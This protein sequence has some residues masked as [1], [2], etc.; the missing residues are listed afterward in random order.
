MIKHKILVSAAIIVAVFLALWS[1][2][3]DDDS[4][5]KSDGFNREE[6]LV[7]WADNIIIPAYKAFQTHVKSLK[8]ASATFTTTPNEANLKAL[9]KA[10]KD[11]YLKFQD[12]SMFEIGPAADV[13]FRLFLNTYPAAAPEESFIVKA[14]YNLEHTGSEALQGFP[15]LDYLLY[16]LGG[17]K[18]SDS[19]I[20]S[21]YTGSNASSYIEYLN[22]IV[23]RMESLTDKVAGQWENSYRDA[24]VD[25]S[26]NTVL[27]SANLIVNELNQYYEKNFRDAKISI[28]VGLLSSN[29]LPDH[30]EG[31]YSQ[32]YSKA[33]FNE[34]LDAIQ[35]FF[36]GKY[37]GSS[38]TGESLKSYL[39]FLKAK[40]DD[41][42]LSEV[43]ND[44]FNA[45]K[46]SVSNLD[47]NFAE[48][49]KTNNDL[50]KTTYKQIQT[51]VVYLK[52]DMPS[53]MGIQ[54]SYVDSD[55]D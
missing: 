18:S 52:T 54:V 6:M 27:S 32:V 43:I 55:G 34:A 5:K 46:A 40:Q 13:D 26:G 3:S 47:D 14:T 10:W 7:N 33:L 9:R 29:P 4:G 19:K 35:N 21:F 45:I 30:V 36:N 16:G 48:Q 38:A 23:N 17:L 2:K 49:I 25:K 31:Y 28:P 44:Q 12:V 15:A 50:L 20:L 51:N 53:A 1:C 41:K 22:A 42:D 8:S 39:D 24:F 11:A 37:Y